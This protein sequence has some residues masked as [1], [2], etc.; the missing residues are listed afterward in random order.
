[1]I[2]L[3]RRAKAGAP[4]AAPSGDVASEDSLR[5]DGALSLSNNSRTAGKQRLAMY[6]AVGLLAMGGM[7][8]IMQPDAADKAR[9]VAADGAKTVKIST[10]DIV[11]RNVSDKEWMSVSQGQMDSQQKAI[12]T[13]QGD[14]GKLDELQ[15]RIDSSRPRTRASRATARR[16]WAPIREKTMT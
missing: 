8:Y 6:G 12:Q 1:V 11:N 7:V 14:S 10:D 4:A 15:K 16:C 9:Q 3:R 2:D 13:L 5:S